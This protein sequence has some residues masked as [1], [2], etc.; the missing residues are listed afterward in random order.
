MQ[1]GQEDRQRDRGCAMEEKK[2]PFTKEVCLFSMPG[3]EKKKTQGDKDSFK[4]V[5]DK[6]YPDADLSN[7]G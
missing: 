4:R 3:G 2:G 6:V 7:E 1:T 5:R